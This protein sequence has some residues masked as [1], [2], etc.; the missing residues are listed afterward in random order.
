MANQGTFYQSLVLP[1]GPDLRFNYSLVASVAANAL[2]IAIKDKNGNDPAPGN[3]VQIPIR[4]VT[5]TTGTYA[6]VNI[7]AALSIVVPDATSLALTVSVAS[8]LYVYAMNNAGVIELALSPSSYWEEGIVQTTVAVSGGSSLNSIYSTTQRTNLAISRLGRIEVTLAAATHW[9]NAPTVI[10]S[11]LFPMAKQLVIGTAQTASSTTTSASFV[12]LSTSPAVT[13]TSQRTRFYKISGAFSGQNSAV[14]RCQWQI[15]A[16]AGAPTT[17]FNQ[18]ASFTQNVGSDELMFTVYGIF[19]LT[20][21][22]AYTFTLQAQTGG[23]TLTIRNDVLIN[24][25]VLIAEEI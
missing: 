19:L 25:A 11:Q 16:T 24:G 15:T 5:L 10:S 20:T 22:T 6:V 12:T 23:G 3:P 21:G 14:N 17:I 9:S 2:T 18:T 4:N 1:D 7:T 8:T 13:I